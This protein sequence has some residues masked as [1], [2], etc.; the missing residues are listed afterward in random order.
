MS[1]YQNLKSLFLK[2][3]QSQEAVLLTVCS[4]HG[5]AHFVCPYCYLL[6]HG[7]MPGVPHFAHILSKK[8]SPIWRS[9][10]LLSTSLTVLSRGAP[11]PPSAQHWRNLNMSYISH[12]HFFICLSLEGV[13]FSGLGVLISRPSPEKDSLLWPTVH[14][15]LA[16]Q[17]LKKRVF[18]LTL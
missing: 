13:P 16:H 6:K 17:I 12:V 4:T 5:W 9:L 7:G 1:L 11:F 14:E 3:R 18:S 10:A 2:N 8:S 15:Q